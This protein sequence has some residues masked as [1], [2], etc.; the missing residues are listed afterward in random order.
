M[1]EMNANS[2]PQ[3]TT[4]QHHF[5]LESKTI[6]AVNHPGAVCAEVEVFASGR[7]SGKLRK[8]RYGLP[9]CSRSGS[10]LW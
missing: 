4:H 1:T 5:E 8:L 6:E 2:G 3:C 9:C 10:A 7:L